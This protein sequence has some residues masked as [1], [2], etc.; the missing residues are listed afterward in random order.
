[1][2]LADFIAGSHFTRYLRR[3]R[4]IYLDVGIPEAAM[5]RVA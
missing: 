5:H 4:L 2:A 1:M 3:M